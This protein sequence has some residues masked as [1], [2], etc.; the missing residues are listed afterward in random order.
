MRS[1]SGY[2]AGFALHIIKITGMLNNYTHW[3]HRSRMLPGSYAA[4]H[5]SGDSRNAASLVSLSGTHVENV[6][7]VFVKKKALHDGQLS[8]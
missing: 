5:R 8:H 6:N 2:S 1:I 7:R 3:E 4:V